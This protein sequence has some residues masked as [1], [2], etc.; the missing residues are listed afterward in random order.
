MKE[1]MKKVY[2]FFADGFEEIEA[3]AS[4]DILRRAGLDV[5]LVSVMDNEIVKGAHQISVFC[6][7]NIEN[8]DFYDASLL[9]LPGGMPGAQTLGECEDLR[10]ALTQ[11]AEKGIT[12]AAI[13]AAPMVLGQLGLLKGKRATCYPGF[14]QFLDGA[15]YTAN[16][17][18][19]AGNLITG[20]GPAAALP[21]A[22]ALVKHLIGEAKE[23]ELKEA[24]CYTH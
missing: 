9:L 24:M 8:C 22:F 13:C 20:K 2:V 10:R 12:L 18:E 21:F 7:V 1:E 19:H 23:K 17:V 5:V 6:D 4:V 14:E 3:F 15:D 11:G 16:L